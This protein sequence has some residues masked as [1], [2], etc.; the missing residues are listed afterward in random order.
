MKNP[1]WPS[2]CVT[3]AGTSNQLDVQ[4]EWEENTWLQHTTELSPWKRKRKKVLYNIYI[5]MGK[6]NQLSFGK[7]KKRESGLQNYLHG[8][9]SWQQ[10]GL[11][12]ADDADDARI[13]RSE[14]TIAW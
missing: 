5:M 7:G 9:Y 4:H 3:P 14:R 2:S 8:I 11:I 10:L 1:V 12:I 13:P 6:G